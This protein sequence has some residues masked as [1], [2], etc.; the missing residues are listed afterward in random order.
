[1]DLLLYTIVKHVL[2]PASETIPEFSNACGECPQ[3]VARNNAYVPMHTSR[4]IKDGFKR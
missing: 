2:F 3:E 1:M 4:A